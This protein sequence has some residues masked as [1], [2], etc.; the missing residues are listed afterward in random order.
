MSIKCLTA[1]VCC[2]NVAVIVLIT[3]C[4]RLLDCYKIVLKILKTLLGSIYIL[5]FNPL[6][7]EGYSGA[8]V[9]DLKYKY[10]LPPFHFNSLIQVVIM[11]TGSVYT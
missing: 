2:N 8:I 10:I 11:I 9:C 1:A 3:V 6:M 4:F 7:S 5:N